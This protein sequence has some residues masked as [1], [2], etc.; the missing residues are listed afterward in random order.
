MESAIVL[1]FPAMSRNLDLESLPN[2]IRFWRLQRG[3]TLKELSAITGIAFGH[4]AK[5]ETGVRELNMARL[6]RIAQALDVPPADLLPLAFGGLS[7]RERMLVDTYRD[8]P[9]GLR[10]SLEAVAESQ[11]PFRGQPEVVPLGT[12]KAS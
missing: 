2:R 11:Q 9:D 10:K 6:E 5:L 7:P 3:H 4:L 1:Q 12:R 8:V